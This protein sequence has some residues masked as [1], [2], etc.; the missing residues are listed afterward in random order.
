MFYPPVTFRP[1]PE[2]SLRL[3]PPPGSAFSVHSLPPIYGTGSL[4]LSLPSAHARMGS[5]PY[6]GLPR[7]VRA[8]CRV[9]V[10]PLSGFLLPSPLDRFSDP[11]ALGIHSFR[12]FLPAPSRTSL[13]AT[14]S[15]ALRPAT[16]DCRFF[17]RAARLQPVELQSLAPGTEPCSPSLLLHNLREPLLSWSSHL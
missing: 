14:C 13:E 3:P 1:L 16:C 2:D 6:R 10:D 5:L 8:A 17:G 11:S 4:R 7:P 9:W 15:L 12:V